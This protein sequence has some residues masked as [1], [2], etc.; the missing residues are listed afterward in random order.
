MTLLDVSENLLTGPLPVFSKATKTFHTFNA[1]QNLF[2]GQIPNWVAPPLES[3]FIG[4]LSRNGFCA[5][6]DG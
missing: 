1:A 6:A 4:M 3:V 5:L 2:S